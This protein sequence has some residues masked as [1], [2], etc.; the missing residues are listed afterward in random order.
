[1]TGDVYQRRELLVYGR[2]D[3][4]PESWAFRVQSVTK[5]SHTVHLTLLLCLASYIPSIRL[6][7]GYRPT[8]REILTTLLS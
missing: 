8:T 6:G 3:V 7:L 4:I 5:G 2:G 1:M